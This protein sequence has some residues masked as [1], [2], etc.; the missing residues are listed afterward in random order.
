MMQRSITP[1]IIIGSLHTPDLVCKIISKVYLLKVGIQTDITFF[2]GI[3]SSFY[4][5]NFP[6]VDA[7]MSEILLFSI[8]KKVKLTFVLQSSKAS[9]LGSSEYQLLTDID[10]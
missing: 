1:P 2:I 10:R 6:K 9:N 7:I 8:R 3:F 4:I 5:L